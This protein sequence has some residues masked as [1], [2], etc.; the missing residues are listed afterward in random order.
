M[1]L[2]VIILIIFLIHLTNKIFKQKILYSEVNNLFYPLVFITLWSSINLF[3]SQS[4]K[5]NLFNLSNKINN[6]SMGFFLL[7]YITINYL[8]RLNTK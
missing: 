3:L 6:S 2:T 8:N 7:M 5:F 4:E 1:S